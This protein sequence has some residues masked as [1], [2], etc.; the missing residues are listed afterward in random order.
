MLQIHNNTLYPQNKTNDCYDELREWY[1]DKNIA[2]I[3]VCKNYDGIRGSDCQETMVV[4]GEQST[5]QL[6][7]AI[8]DNKK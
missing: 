1:A 8:N 4:L 2:R 7:R 3:M 6:H 5:K